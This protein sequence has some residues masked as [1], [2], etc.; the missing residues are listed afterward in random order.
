M[1][2]SYLIICLLFT[3]CKGKFSIQ[4]PNDPPRSKFSFEFTGRLEK[5]E[6][7][8]YSAKL[9]YRERPLPGLSQNT[10]E[11]E[12]QIKRND[13]V[14]NYVVTLEDC[15]SIYYLVKW[16]DDWK[17][18]ASNIHILDYSTNVTDSLPMEVIRSFFKQEVIDR[19]SERFRTISNEY[20]WKIDKRADTTFV[21]ILDQN[22]SLRKTYVYALDTI[23]HSIA[24]MKII[25]Y[26]GDSTIIYKTDPGQGYVYLFSKE[27]LRNK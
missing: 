3:G 13:T 19:V 9:N 27:V 21:Y 20:H 22:K 11:Y 16:N 12:F 8:F 1:R 10:P 2:I 26:L 17:C 24:A 7:A 23:G 14:I 6:D 5:L 18:N 15:Q 25:N 4:I